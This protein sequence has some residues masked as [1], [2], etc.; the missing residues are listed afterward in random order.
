MLSSAILCAAHAR[1][2]QRRESTL[3]K[4]HLVERA[5]LGHAQRLLAGATRAADLSQTVERVGAAIGLDPLPTR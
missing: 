1:L 2:T 5:G 3:N 4:R